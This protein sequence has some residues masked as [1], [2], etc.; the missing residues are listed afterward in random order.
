M[1]NCK[2]ASPRLCYLAKGKKKAIR[3]GKVLKRVTKGD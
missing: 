1:K 3:G 2:A